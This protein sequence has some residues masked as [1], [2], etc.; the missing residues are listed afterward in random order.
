MDRLEGLPLF[1]VCA[2]VCAVDPEL[3]RSPARSDFWLDLHFRGISLKTKTHGESTGV[4]K[5][6]FPISAQRC[7]SPRQYRRSDWRVTACRSTRAARTVGGTSSHPT[8]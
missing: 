7:W 3:Q 6:G 4:A 2:E 8:G 5:Q 1:Q